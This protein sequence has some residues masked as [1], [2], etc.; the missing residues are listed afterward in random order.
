MYLHIIKINLKSKKKK[1]RKEN[2]ILNKLNSS[3]I[4]QHRTDIPI[5]SGRTR[6]VAKDQTKRTETQQGEHCHQGL[7]VPLSCNLN[8][9]KP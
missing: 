2:Y 7:L 9:F 8:F 3:P 1:E 5:P 4:K 6:K